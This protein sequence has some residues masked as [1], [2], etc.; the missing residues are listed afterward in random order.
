MKSQKYAVVIV[1]SGIAG[2]SAALRISELRP[3]L[4]VLIL[5]KTAL[6]QTSSAL[7]QGGVAARMR[8][9][10]L[11]KKQHIDDTLLA[12]RGLNNRETVTFLVDHVEDRIRDLER[13][14]LTFDHVHNDY[15]YALEGG[16]SQRRILHTADSTG[17]SILNTLW[18]EASRRRNIEFQF[19]A[20]VMRLLKGD[21][22]IAGLEYFD[23]EFRQLHV[24]YTTHII[25]A[26]GGS[27]QLFETTTNPIGAIGSGIALAYRLG[28][29]V[30]G[31]QYVQ[32]HPTALFHGKMNPAFL[33][34]EAV[35]GAG[36]WLINDRG[37]RFVFDYDERGELATRD[38]VSA[39][40]YQERNAGKTKNVYLDMRHLNHEETAKHFS[41]IYKTLMGLALNPERDLIPVTPAA[42][43]QCGG[44]VTDVNGRTSIAGML[45]VGEC[46]NNGLH[47]ANRLASNSLSEGLVF[48]WQ[49]GDVVANEL[50]MP[51][52]VK[53]RVGTAFESGDH[54]SDL[55]VKM[56]RMLT[57]A[58]HHPDA[59]ERLQ[60]MAWIRSKEDPGFTSYS[61]MQIDAIALVSRLI[62]EQKG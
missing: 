25:L 4:N 56:R 43:F 17:A 50:M 2:L 8:G 28:A 1:G 9:S 27:G 37:E 57:V 54:R 52:T 13:M 3:E 36:A 39:A 59:E 53:R 42:H 51:T 46:A 19:G 18:T 10:A 60:A 5:A 26:T 21:D 35:R 58:F 41:L 30:K 22:G 61:G 34:S 24:L 29:E 32:F 12:G 48:G 44:I 16:H 15:D 55:I 38:V 62:L 7:A 31:M 14:G 20:S 33:I 23:V 6:W 11:D 49:A 47:G 40:I 45:A